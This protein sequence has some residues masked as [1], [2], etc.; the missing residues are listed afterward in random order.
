MNTL[1][2]ISSMRGRVAGLILAAALLSPAL[3][4]ADGGPFGLGIILGDPSG[5]SAKLFLDGRHA[6]DF[7]LDFSFRD[8]AMYI[9]ADYLLHIKQFTSRKAGNH[10]FLPYVGV[11]GKL[12]IRDNHDDDHHGHDHDNS[13]SLGVRVPLGIAW[14]PG[15]PDSRRKSI[16]TALRKVRPT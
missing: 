3:A 14:V 11:G 5:L 15:G 4:R 12:G 10:L 6:V 16:G 2:L 13:G 7:A 9:H 8:D 1:T